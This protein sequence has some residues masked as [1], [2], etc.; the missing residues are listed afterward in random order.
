MRLSKKISFLIAIVTL[1]VTSGIDLSAKTIVEK[2]EVDS[3]RAELFFSDNPGTFDAAHSEDKTKLT[4]YI[5]GADVVENSK[6]ASG[7]GKIETVYLQAAGDTLRASVIFA[8][9]SGFTIREMFFSRS[10][11]IESVEWSELSESEVNYRTGLL[12]IADNLDETAEKFLLKSAAT[13]NAE[14]GAELGF[15]YMRKG[16]IS[17]AI[18]YLRSAYE[19]GAGEPDVYAA[20]SQLF[21]DFN[22]P[23]K[24]KAFAVLFAEKSYQKE[25]PKVIYEIDYPEDMTA[26]VY[27]S[28]I[29][30]KL[31]RINPPATDTT[32]VAETDTSRA[33][34]TI[35]GSAFADR[36]KSSL[37]DRLPLAA[38][39]AIIAFVLLA[40]LIFVRY[41]IWRKRKLSEIEEKTRKK[42]AAGDTRAEIKKAKAE[43][44]K[45][46]YAAAQYRS[47]Q[48][49]AMR[50]KQEELK[51]EAEKKKADSVKTDKPK[52]TAK[53]TQSDS[54]KPTPSITPADK[55]V[56]EKEKPIEK[57]PEE[58]ESK[59]KP[60]DEKM[61]PRLKLALRLQEEENKIKSSSGSTD[62]KEFRKL[63]DVA[64][65]LGVKPKAEKSKKKEEPADEEKISKLRE[66]FSD[67]KKK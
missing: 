39:Y 49:A 40:A 44:G 29:R 26:D 16:K 14:A 42:Y 8:G 22:F 67:R 46:R 35:V 27:L 13:N 19:S 10:L 34:S 41:I 9:P 58:P 50:K 20:I 52:S 21:E 54:F 47:A 59:S 64:K 31:A 24:S 56:S 3:A 60:E 28:E 45:S 25:F 38:T 37:K 2:I 65:K 17:K 1:S 51:K 63:E 18:D 32:N 33:D 53:K 36:K 12:A 48:E 43:L 6:R 61:S 55:P 62:A 7:S 4:L 23:E 5:F 11:R 57:A 15:L 30:A 66:K